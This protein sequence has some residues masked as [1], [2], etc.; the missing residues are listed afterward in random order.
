MFQ[1]QFTAASHGCF[2]PLPAAAAPAAPSAPRAQSPL[3]AFHLPQRAL[4]L[5]WSCPPGSRAAAPS[6]GASWRGTLACPPHPTQ[7][8]PRL[9]ECARGTSFIP[10]PFAPPVFF[11]SFSLSFTPI[12]HLWSS[13]RAAMAS[14]FSRSCRACRSLPSGQSISLRACRFEFRRRL[15]KL[16]STAVKHGSHAR[17]ASAYHPTFRR[18]ITPT[19]FS[20]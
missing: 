13:S 1:T 15:D 8:M 5:S 7:P 9:N 16:S 2:C 3:A 18:D 10:V 20:S 14:A 11:F 12:V 19:K 17:R 4:G 6:G